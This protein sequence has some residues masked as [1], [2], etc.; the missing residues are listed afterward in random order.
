MFTSDVKIK[1]HDCDPAGILFYANI[2]KL[3]HDIYQEL[4]ESIKDRNFFDD[5]S[6]ALPIIKATAEY[7]SPMKSGDVLSTNIIVS[8]LNDSSFELTNLFYDRI[9]KLH[10]EVKT[11]HVAVDKSDFKKTALPMELVELL[12][13]NR[14]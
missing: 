14:V 11:V 2:F 10:A 12:R 3:S 8:Q 6:I 13:A 9:K 7:F 5:E 1:F 4:L